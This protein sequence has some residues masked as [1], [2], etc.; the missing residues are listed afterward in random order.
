M[1]S[2]M[3][4]VVKKVYA[5]KVS[6]PKRKW[7]DFKNYVKKLKHYLDTRPILAWCFRFML[8]ITFVGLTWWGVWHFNQFALI[9]TRT[10]AHYAD[11]GKELKRRDNLIPMLIS[12]TREY[13]SH[14]SDSFK[15]V[16]DA[17]EK[18]VAT[19]K[20]AAGMKGTQGVGQLFSKLFALFEQY[21]E[22]KATQSV[23]DLI[24]E[25]VTTENRI[26][27]AKAYYNEDARVYNQL[28]TS[29][30]GKF[31]WR[32][33]GCPRS[34]DYIGEE[35]EILGLSKSSIFRKAGENDE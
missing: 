9:I 8:V 14:E 16:S 24:R 23:Q 22:L 30:P 34:M 6:Y 18:L 25:L 15:Y 20:P 1:A 21:P 12:F 32:L 26:A 17:R 19:K 31:L 5:E 10:E 27:E 4:S 29:F 3:S 13:K 28:T 33:Y 2:S 35:D 7:I 11:V